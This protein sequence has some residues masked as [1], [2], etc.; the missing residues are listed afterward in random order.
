MSHQ[1]IIEI[2][3][4]LRLKQ[5]IPLF[6]LQRSPYHQP[7]FKDSPFQFSI[8]HSKDVVICLASVIAAVGVDIEFEDENLINLDSEFLNTYEKSQLAKNHNAK[9]F[10][11]LHT[12][13]EAISKALGLGVYLNHHT[14]DV[15]NDFLAYQ[16]RQWF[17]TT[18]PVIDQYTISL[19]TTL[20]NMDINI[21][22]IVL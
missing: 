12:R 4:K 6:D 18:L 21:S 13:K 3:N 16:N 10:F 14:I 17:L 2:A 19:A 22:E 1:S 8:A 5:K 7:Y 15:Q 9:Y 11:Y 20:Y